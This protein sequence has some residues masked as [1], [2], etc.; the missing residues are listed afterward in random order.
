MDSPAPW[1][2]SLE[3]WCSTAEWWNTSLSPESWGSSADSPSTPPPSTPE[4]GTAAGLASATAAV[5]SGV[6]FEAV[7]EMVRL[8]AGGPIDTDAPL[9]E[10]GIDS[11]GAVELRN[12]LQAAAGAGAA[13]PSTLVFD[14][15]TARQLD[16]YIRS[17]RLQQHERTAFKNGA[18]DARSVAARSPQGL[19]PGLRVGK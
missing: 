8:T 4:A 2:C 17:D 11:L 15:P 6:S 5:P 12:Q 9:M 3:S 16:A 19:A 14:H 10:V 1:C 13:F 7:L 18:S